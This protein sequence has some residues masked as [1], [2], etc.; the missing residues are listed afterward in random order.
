M[1]T[2]NAIYIMG[3]RFKPNIWKINIYKTQLKWNVERLIWIAFY[4]KNNSQSLFGQ[5]PK[6]VIKKILYYFQY[7]IFDH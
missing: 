3:S 7:S 5:L 6:E 2:K 1:A 4:A